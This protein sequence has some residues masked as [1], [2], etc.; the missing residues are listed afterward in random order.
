MESY[1]LLRVRTCLCFCNPIPFF[2]VLVNES[3]S[4]IKL[5]EHR[6]VFL[7]SLEFEYSKSDVKVIHFDA[8]SHKKLVIEHGLQELDL[9]TS[10]GTRD[11]LIKIS[12]LLDLQCLQLFLD[13]HRLLFSH[14]TD[15]T[16]LLNILAFEVHEVVVG[17]IFYFLQLFLVFLVQHVQRHRLLKILVQNFQFI[18]DSHKNTLEYFFFKIFKDFDDFFISGHV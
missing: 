4:L 17:L 14:F 18:F 8:C 16:V 6:E 5:F 7:I 2:R 1:S 9:F 13:L 10:L 11:F 15:I 12:K 3:N